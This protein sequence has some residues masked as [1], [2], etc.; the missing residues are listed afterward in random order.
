MKLRKIYKKIIIVAL[1]LLSSI[2]IH[3]LNQNIK[4]D[5]LTRDFRDRSIEG[6]TLT[7]AFA[8]GLE[9]T[10][11]YHPV[12][13]IYDYEITDPRSVF[14]TTKE[15]PFI[16]KTGDVFVTQESPFPNIFGFHQLMSF[17]VGGHAALNNGNNQFIEAVGFPQD[18]EKI[19]N[20]IKDPSN[21]SHDF[22]VGVRQSSTNYWMLPDF[23]GEKDIS[24]PYYGSYYREKFVVLRVKEINDDE[25]KQ[26]MIYANKHLENR[27]LYNFL[28]ITDTKNKFYCTDLISRS[29]RYGL[30][31]NSIDENYPRVLNDNGFVTT[32]NDLILSRDT[33]VAVYVENTDGIR[34]VYYLEDVEV[35]ITQLV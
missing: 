3:G 31:S 5:R 30:N 11:M 34:H 35:D 26:T 8:N 24:Y 14:Y 18:D 13:R 27:S 29:Y 12:E 9:E 15:Q 10:R 19:I 33:Y 17:F 22:S 1:I 16:G 7:I 25:L 20:I 2:F 32:V 21:G 4:V 6:E 23:R 28:F